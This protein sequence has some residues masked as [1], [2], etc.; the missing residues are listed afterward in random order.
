M[1][2]QALI[3]ENLAILKIDQVFDLNQYQEFEQ[4][5]LELFKT[6]KFILCEFIQAQNPNFLSAI[7]NSLLN[8]IPKNS[9]FII[10][11]EAIESV[12]TKNILDALKNIQ[13]IYA[14]KVFEAIQL[15]NSNKKLVYNINQVDSILQ[16]QLRNFTPKEKIEERFSNEEIESILYNL[17]RDATKVQLMQNTYQNEIKKYEMLSTVTKIEISHDFYQKLKNLEQ[18]VLKALTDGGAL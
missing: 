17:K 5:V 4:E 16:A 1:T 12:Q 6:I 7:K 13:N 10:V 8:K 3:Y 15:E 2:A 9:K 18:K 11:S 14:K